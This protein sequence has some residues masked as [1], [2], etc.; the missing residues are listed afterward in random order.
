MFVCLYQEEQQRLAAKEQALKEREEKRK[1]ADA[2]LVSYQ[3][4]KSEEHQRG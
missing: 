1:E 2:K 3:R 4:E